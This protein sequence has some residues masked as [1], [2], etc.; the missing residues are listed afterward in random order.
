MTTRL[1]PV[2][3]SVALATM[4]FCTALPL[5]AGPPSF[6]PDDFRAR[7]DALRELIPDSAALLHGGRGGQDR[8]RQENNF[9]YL[10][11]V[12]T[13]GAAVLIRGG[14]S[15][16]PRD[17]G[18]SADHARDARAH[19]WL[20]AHVA[21]LYSLFAMALVHAGVMHSHGFVAHFIAGR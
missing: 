11:G 12:R 13:P 15:C 6:G 3:C 19:R 8:F 4:I 5:A 16:Q 1:R 21:L 10:T 2:L 9:Y 14:T 17:D 7:R 20:I 18:P